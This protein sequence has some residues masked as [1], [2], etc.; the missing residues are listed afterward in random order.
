M[1]NT[2]NVIAALP[3]IADALGR[4]Y[5]VK[6]LIGGDRAYTD[7]KNIHLPGL[8]LHS[9]ENVLN[10]AR[11]YLDH[12]SAHL[13]ITDFALL[14]EAR[15]SPIEK[16]VWNL[17]EDCMVEERLAAIYP[18]CRQNFKWLIRHVFLGQITEES[19]GGN[20]PANHI[21]NW[22]LYYLRSLSVSELGMERDKLASMIDDKW[23]DLRL[24]LEPIVQSV[25][26][27][28]TDTKSC[29][30][31]ARKIVAIMERY[32]QKRQEKLQTSKDKKREDTKDDSS[33]RQT[34]D[35]PQNNRQ[36]NVDDSARSKSQKE[37]S[38]ASSSSTNNNTK[39]EDSPGATQEGD[40]SGHENSDASGSANSGM[41]ALNPLQ[42]LAEA[43]TNPE[44]LEPL[45]MAAI[46]ASELESMEDE[47]T[48]DKLSVALPINASFKAYTPE[49][50]RDIRR[51]TASL[52]TKLNGLLQARN[53]TRTR[54]ARS[55]KV[56][57]RRIGR[58]A[59]KDTRVFARHTCRQGVNTAVHI[60]LDAS[61]SM[62]NDKVNLASRATYALALALENVAGVNVGVT[63]FPAPFYYAKV[64]E[65][66]AASVA[67][68]KRHGQRMHDR[69][70]V[71]CCGGTPLAEALWWLLQE[72]LHLKEDRKIILILSDGYPDSLTMAKEALKA[73]EA[74][75]FEAYGLGIQT[76]AMTTLLPKEQSGAIYELRELVSAVFELLR[77]A[78][79]RTKGGRH[80]A[81]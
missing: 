34:D 62:E 74:H 46:V 21:F 25:P 33:A 13:R 49:E 79:F 75:G 40:T 68:I 73:L 36:D 14:N 67:I 22:I 55:G 38:E 54:I 47:N 76:N 10:L 51:E 57:L 53:E 63:S 48:R 64:S 3:L 52:R 43:I 61:Y 11:G 15:L 8:P 58:L 32:V 60:L 20:S 44:N 7:G 2:K 35:S 77:S 24:Q 41:K 16:H 42:M 69:F 66:D 4:K 70:Q 78:L 30:M 23:P 19:E 17:L 45:D 5:G 6:V 65:M 26:M 80:V 37:P 81:S 28:C 71:G 18:G 12:E 39:E 59:C 56:D 9:D 27:A 31:V 1:R 50:L 29:I 72:M